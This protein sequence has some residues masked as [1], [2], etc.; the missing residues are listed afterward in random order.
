M[1]IVAGFGIK[2]IADKVE[3]N[4]GAAFTVGLSQ[5]STLGLSSIC[6]YQPIWD[7]QQQ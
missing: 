1:G 2:V 4:N 3:M 6:G 7:I 5:A